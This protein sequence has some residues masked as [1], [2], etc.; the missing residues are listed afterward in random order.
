MSTSKKA[1]RRREAD[2]P[3]HRVYSHTFSNEFGRR[4]ELTVQDAVLD[5]KPAVL[6]WI[7]GPESFSENVVTADEAKALSALLALALGAAT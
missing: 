5:R 2:L 1:R 6:I 3:P 4:I 7:K